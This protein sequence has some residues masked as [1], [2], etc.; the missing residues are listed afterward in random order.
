MVLFHYSHSLTKTVPYTEGLELLKE[1]GF[2]ER[3]F[4]DVQ[5]RCL[6][7]TR[8]EILDT[9]MRWTLH[10]DPPDGEEQFGK[11]PRLSARVLWLC[12]V[13]GSGKSRISRSIATRL[14]ELQRLGSLYCCDYR[15]R[16]TLNPETLFSTIAQHLASHDPLRRQHLLAAIKDD[17]AI[18][19]TKICRQQYQHFIVQPSTDLPIVGDT[20][21][22]IDAFD[23]IGDIEDRAVAL[24]ILSRHAHELPPGLRIVVTSRF[25]DDIQEALQSPK[26]VGVDFMLMEDI[27]TDLTA[28]DISHYVH[29]K[30]GNIRDLEPADLN[31]LAM[32]AGDSF[33]WASTACRYIRNNRDRRGMQGPKD[34]LPLFLASN[35]GLDELY[36]RILDEHFGE[37]SAEALVKLKLILGLILRAEEPISLRTVS[38]LISQTS[39]G[40]TPSTNLHLHDLQ[41][42]VRHL[43]SLLVNTHDIDQAISPLHTSFADFLQDVKRHH[44]YL[45][46]IEEAN[47]RLG[48]GCLDI[49]ER[50][51]R[52]NICQIPTSYKAN[53]DIEN[54]ETLVKKYI[55]PHLRYA[56]RFWAQHL[57]YLTDVDDVIS[58]KLRDMLSTRFLEWLE[59]MSVTDASFQAPLATLDSSKACS[60]TNYLLMPRA[61]FRS[62]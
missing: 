49:M 29:D 15:N 41:R 25:E 45:I 2:A 27:P 23:E 35:Q 22:V 43:A 3:A 4:G 32:A 34:R 47:R 51:L 1:M 46:D 14:Q 60:S 42:I 18:R 24:D 9:I 17:K 12:G 13:A 36:T 20:V 31:Q 37:D 44:K 52:F 7:G 40:P 59:V 19:T 38:E 55:S 58:S 62:R 5:G 16:A 26:A 57:S 33:Q 39:S 56:S 30:L 61:N 28:R 50:E 48:L 54:L 53:K 21:I 10:A 11:V 8:T 6:D